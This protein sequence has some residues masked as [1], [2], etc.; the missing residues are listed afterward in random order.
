MYH[1]I[2]PS[3]QCT[4]GL[5]SA[6]NVNFRK[7]LKTVNTEDL[8]MDKAVSTRREHAIPGEIKRDTAANIAGGKQ[9]K[10]NKPGPGVIPVAK[11]L[12]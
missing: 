2:G 5:V 6:F 3:F 7:E 10:L 4:V 11:W 12:N 8:D 1:R 9:V